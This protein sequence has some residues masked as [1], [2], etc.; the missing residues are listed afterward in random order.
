[1]FIDVENWI[2]FNAKWVGGSEDR[3]SGAGNI[4]KTIRRIKWK[5]SYSKKSTGEENFYA[6]SGIGLTQGWSKR[7]GARFEIFEEGNFEI[8]RKVEG[9]ATELEGDCEKKYNRRYWW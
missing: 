9:C 3:N 5:S 6:I 1:L 7:E 8:W 4:Q 2:N